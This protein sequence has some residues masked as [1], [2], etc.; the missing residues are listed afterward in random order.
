MYSNDLNNAYLY[1]HERRIDEMRTAAQGY[2]S[3]Y[4][5]RSKHKEVVISVIS[6]LLI[7]IW[8]VF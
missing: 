1:E 2:F 8:F 4:K 7:T 6:I 3:N 5:R